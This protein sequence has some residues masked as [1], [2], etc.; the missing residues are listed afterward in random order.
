[1]ND[2][3]GEDA[4]QTQE[5][6]QRE[7]PCNYYQ[8][9][10]VGP[11]KF[12]LEMALFLLIFGLAVIHVSD[13]SF[14]G[15]TASEPNMIKEIGKN[16]FT[17]ATKLIWLIWLLLT[18]F[19]VTLNMV[20]YPLEQ[21]SMKYELVGPKDGVYRDGDFVEL[22]FLQFAERHPTQAV[23]T[24]VASAVGVFVPYGLEAV[25]L[26]VLSPILSFLSLILEAKYIKH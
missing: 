11:G 22:S 4:L 15:D 25:L 24:A 26:F 12:I 19:Y 20:G 2:F 16:K 3:G 6:Q 8:Y 21:S 23:L 18:G 7:H 1:M 13:R 14:S 5:N 10:L 17:K 9:L